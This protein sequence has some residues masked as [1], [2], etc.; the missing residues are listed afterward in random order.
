MPWPPTPR[1]RLRAIWGPSCLLM[2]PYL[3]VSLANETWPIAEVAAKSVL[4][5]LQHVVIHASNHPDYAEAHAEWRAKI[6]AFSKWV[7]GLLNRQV[8]SKA[9]NFLEDAPAAGAEQ[10]AAAVAAAASTEAAAAEEEAAA[11]EEPVKEDPDE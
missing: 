2:Q 5:Y 9:Q 1:E 6:P 4:D 8:A 10:E 7:K 3:S 11:K